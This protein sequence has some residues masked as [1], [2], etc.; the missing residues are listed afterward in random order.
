[1]DC[2][3]R[4]LH[5]DAAKIEGTGFK[6]EVKEVTLLLLREVMSVVSGDDLPSVEVSA[7]S[8]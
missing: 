5:I 6:C 3:C 7:G 1:M 4:H 8:G 2:V